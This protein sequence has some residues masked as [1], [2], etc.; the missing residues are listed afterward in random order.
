M[1][2]KGKFGKMLLGGTGTVHLFLGCLIGVCVGM[3][4]G[5]NLMLLLG[6]VVLVLVNTNSPMALLGIVIG[7]ILCLTLAPITF[8]IGY[9]IIHGIGLENAFRVACEVPVLPWL[10]LHVYC[11][12]GGIPVAAVVGVIVGIVAVRLVKARRA[13]AAEAAEQAAAGKEK[14]EKD[15]IIRKWGFVV[16]GIII[17]AAVAVDLLA[18]GYIFERALVYALQRGVG[19]EVNVA[20]VNASLFKGSIEIKGMQIT[21]P[22]RPAR[23]VVAVDNLTG[24]LSIRDLLAKRLVIDKV[25]VSTVDTNVPRESPGKVFDSAGREILPEEMAEDALARYVKIGGD[26]RKYENYLKRIAHWLKQRHA[27]KKREK[28][29]DPKNR[30]AAR[31]DERG[32]LALS[33]DHLLAKRPAWTIRELIVEK[34]QVEKLKDPKAEVKKRY[35]EGAK[36]KLERQVNEFRVVAVELSSNPKLNGE[37]ARITVT[38]KNRFSGD[39][40]L[41]FREADSNHKLKMFVPDLPVGEILALSNA[42]PVSVGAGTLDIRADGVFNGESINMPLALHVTGLKAQPRE[43]KKM[44]GLEA[45]LVKEIFDNFSEGTFTALVEGPIDSPRLKVDED[46]MVKSLTTGLAASGKL[47]L[48]G[49]VNEKLTFI[50]GELQGKFK[51][52]VGDKLPDALPGKLKDLLPEKQDKKEKPED[53]QGKPEDKLPE[54]VKDLLDLSF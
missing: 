52:A 37:P 11:L 15:W 35:G 48:L 39:L 23:N 31:A 22:D 29:A 2:V 47:E 17:L 51:E 27:E 18:L 41:D 38:G 26:L 44:F 33:A 19:A 3:V 25:L 20:E 45:P 42:V 34:L 46:R 5:V 28:E 30:L 14:D 32:Y 13:G 8:Q 6:I 16:S 53:K 36:K 10:D 54:K 43:S 50:R 4:P 12:I 24:D 49:R 40:V 21:D 7:K 9:V 1:K